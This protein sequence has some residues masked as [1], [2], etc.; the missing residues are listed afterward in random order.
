MATGTIRS[1]LAEA[2]IDFFIYGQALSKCDQR[3]DVYGAFNKR[4]A[5][6]TGRYILMSLATPT[7]EEDQSS[8]ARFYPILVRTSMA[9]PQNAPDQY[10][11]DGRISSCATV[12]C[13]G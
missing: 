8:D 9:V 3:R 12:T 7:K 4:F 13:G 11:F 2:A 10:R 1:R 5:A 6:M